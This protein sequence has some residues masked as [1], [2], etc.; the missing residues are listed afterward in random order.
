MTSRVH[1]LQAL[2]VYAEPLVARRRVVVF[3]EAGTGVEERLLELGALTVVRLGPAD[4]LSSLRVAR[5]D[6]ALVTD[7]G[8]FDDP[9][10]LLA[11]VRLAVGDAGVALVAAAN[12][13]VAGPDAV[14]AFDYYDLF[15]LVARQFADVRMIVRLPFLGVALAE[16]SEEDSPVVSVDTQLVDGEHT[17]EAFVAL[18]SQHG[19]SLDPYAIIELPALD[20]APAP[21]EREDSRVVQLVKEELAQERA[22][23]QALSAQVQALEARASAAADLERELAGR[24]RQIAELSSEV[25]EKRAAAEA[26]RIAA[27]HVE[28]LALR[29]D[30]AERQVARF[31]PEHV[32]AAEAHALELARIEEALFDRARIIQQ[33]EAELA[34]RERMV[35]DL[36]QTLEEHPATRAAPAEQ[37]PQAHRDERVELALAEENTRLRERLD[38]L[39]LDLARREGEAQAAT[40]SITE[41]QRRLDRRGDRPGPAPD[42]DLQGKLAAALDELDALRKAFV[43]EHEARA[44]AESAAAV[45]AGKGVSSSDLPAQ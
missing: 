44:R 24:M 10:D 36:V 20:R 12:R 13:D 3:G 11:R 34:R 25:E 14:G 29:A 41:L 21:E 22:R 5:F 38:A 31:E 15:D 27:A 40:W 2:A 8:L 6:L 35:L 19:V 45:A 42:G 7:L 26:G 28:E 9:E 37:A 18:A 30:R 33:L 43:Q 17:P 23:L 1:P 4:D 16:V 39:A 32:R